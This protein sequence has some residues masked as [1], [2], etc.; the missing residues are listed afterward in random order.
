VGIVTLKRGKQR[1]QDLDLTRFLRKE[2]NDPELLTFWDVDTQQWVL[3]YWVH[4]DQG[5]VNVIEHLGTDLSY[6]DRAWVKNLKASKAGLTC[7]EIKDRLITSA[8]AQY[9]AEQAELEEYNAV[10]DWVQKKSGSP[11]PVLLG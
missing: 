1:L 5:V 6:V 8:K 9:A 7:A 11:V 2:L 3:A 4:K 10:Q